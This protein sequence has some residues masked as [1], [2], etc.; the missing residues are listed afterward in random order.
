MP[1]ELLTVLKAAEAASNWH[2]G[3]KRKGEAGEPYI[4]HLIEVARLVAEATNGQ[5]PH[6][7]AAAF[8]HDA[9]EDQDV[10]LSQVASM[11]G[12]DVAALVGEVTDDRSLPKAERKRLQVEHAPHMSARAKILK[13]A[14]KISNVRTV[15]VNPPSDWPLERRREYVGW[16]RLVVAGLGEASPRLQELFEATAQETERV[17]EG[18]A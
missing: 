7:V 18:A 6:L 2:S 15:G 14:D 4:N 11:F 3:Q 5:D 10:T 12:D 17:I 13:L 16:A 9:V 1:T 8:L